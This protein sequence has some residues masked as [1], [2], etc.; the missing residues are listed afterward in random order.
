M[1]VRTVIIGLIG[2]TSRSTSRVNSIVGICRCRCIF[3]DKPRHIWK[4]EGPKS[5][6]P[7]KRSDIRASSGWNGIVNGIWHLPKVY[8]LVAIQHVN[9]ENKRIPSR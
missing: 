1:V 4:T 2:L 7:S 5:W 3:S 6:W 8:D 9:A